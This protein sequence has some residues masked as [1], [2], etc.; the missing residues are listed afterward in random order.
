MAASRV[1]LVIGL[2]V[3]ASVLCSA[4]PGIAAN[5]VETAEFLIKLLQA[6]RGRIAGNQDLITDTTRGPK[7]FTAEVFAEQTMQK[8]KE[9]NRIDL[10][11]ND[12]PPSSAKL[13]LALLEA[14]KEVVAES[15]IIIN[16]AGVGFKGFI[17]A[18]WGR[19]TAERFSHR[20]GI[21]L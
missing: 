9:E 2:L 8:F 16:K 17:P 14:G 15:Q 3:L 10:R 20:T 5:E 13:L 4:Q 18:K 11:N 21:R 12:L 6:G 1:P 19:M 7:G